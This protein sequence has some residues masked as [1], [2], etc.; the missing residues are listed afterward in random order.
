MTEVSISARIPKELEKEL[1]EFMKQEKIDR[2]IAVRKLLDYGLQEWKLEQALQMLEKGSITFSK[3]AKVADMDVWTF[4]EKIKEAKITWIRVK[5]EE[6]R[7][8]LR[9]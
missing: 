5:P 7:R 1:E 8:E 6:L 2:S 3:A 4:A 9:G